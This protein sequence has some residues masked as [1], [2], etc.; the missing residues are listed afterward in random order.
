MASQLVENTW[1]FIPITFE[2]SVTFMINLVLLIIIII[3]I[4]IIIGLFSIISS[5]NTS[6]EKRLTYKHTVQKIINK[7]KKFIYI[8][9]YTYLPFNFTQY[10]QYALPG[11]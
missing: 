8:Y 3:I 6:I 1:S 2:E 5:S 9:K 10:A 11:V 4:I 7:I